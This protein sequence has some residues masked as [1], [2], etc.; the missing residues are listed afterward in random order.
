M[1]KLPSLGSANTG[2]KNTPILTATAIGSSGISVSTQFTLGHALTD[3]ERLISE[4]E[5]WF[6][7]LT[8]PTGKYSPAWTRKA[9]EQ[10]SAIK[11]GVPAGRKG[12]VKNLASGGPN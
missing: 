9:A 8:Y 5:F 10:D 2:G 12:V 7:R 4:E 6:H 1:P 11:R 3:A